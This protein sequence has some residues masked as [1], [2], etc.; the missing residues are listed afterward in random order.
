MNALG[1]IG[2]VVA[3]I[4]A[5]VV[6]ERSWNAISTGQN[7]KSAQLKPYDKE[8]PR[9]SEYANSNGVIDNEGAKNYF[10]KQMDDGDGKVSCEELHKIKHAV[11]VLVTM[12][13]DRNGNL[14]KLKE[15]E[16][17]TSGQSFENFYCHSYS[18]YLAEQRKSLP[19]VYGRRRKETM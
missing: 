6:T 17:N 5:P 4:V 18:E 12:K 3:F 10:L 9:L 1:K 8:L 7:G 2:A 14:K 16:V 13:P 15:Y 11:I 19:Q